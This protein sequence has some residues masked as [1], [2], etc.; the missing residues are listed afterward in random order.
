MEPVERFGPTKWLPVDPHDPGSEPIRWASP[1]FRL[2]T[3]PSPGS[4]YGKK[5]ILDFNGEPAFAEI[6]IIKM[7]RPKWASVWLSQSFGKLICRDAFWNSPPKPT[8]PES[9]LEFLHDAY[10]ARGGTYGGTWDIIAWPRGRSSPSPSELWFIESKR[11]GKDDIDVQQVSWYD[12]L[13]ATGISRDRFLI[14]E[15]NVPT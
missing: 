4:S 13:R 1:V 3:G 8:V 11:R 5:A 9:V 14:V 12:H 10:T 6:G 7:L 2:W 15:W